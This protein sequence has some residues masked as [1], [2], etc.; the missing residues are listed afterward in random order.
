MTG[1][2]GKQLASITEILA[3]ASQRRDEEVSRKAASKSSFASSTQVPRGPS[4]TPAAASS[5]VDQSVSGTSSRDIV[6]FQRK[7]PKP[8]MQNFL[9]YDTDLPRAASIQGWISNVPRHEPLTNGFPDEPSQASPQET[10]HPPH[11]LVHTEPTVSALAREIDAENMFTHFG[12]GEPVAGIKTTPMCMEAVP[13][14]LGN[15]FSRERSTFG[16]SDVDPEQIL[17]ALERSLGSPDGT[18]VTDWEARAEELLETMRTPSSQ[19]LETLQVFPTNENDQDPRSMLAHIEQQSWTVKDEGPN[20]TLTNIESDSSFTYDQEARA[21]L[22]QLERDSSSFHDG[23][24]SL[25]A[26]QVA[27]LC[28]N[29]QDPKIILAHL[30]HESSMNDDTDSRCML[31][32]L[33]GEALGG[34]VNK[35]DDIGPKAFWERFGKMI[36][37]SPTTWFPA[38]EVTVSPALNLSLLA[39]EPMVARI[40]SDIQ[41]RENENFAALDKNIIPYIIALQLEM[42]GLSWEEIQIWTTYLFSDGFDGYKAC[43]QKDAIVK[44]ATKELDEMVEHLP[45]EDEHYRK[46]E[47]EARLPCRLI[48]SNV[49]ADAGVGDLR[50]FF[51]PFRFVV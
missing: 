21:I 25:Q 35:D 39:P 26:L 3:K 51:S 49:A 8:Q 20:R 28:Q 32:E 11:I 31:A 38:A 41:V 24:P 22:D 36:S 17:A 18:Y 5:S 9:P 40:A 44:Q 23:E 16:S 7:Q 2:L 19:S 43:L 34:N 50:Q 29:Y 37:S 45:K 6:V 14:K 10:E 1:L 27:P 12:V 47:N 46:L 48:V 33:R 42:A 4:R 13:K 30:E 15:G